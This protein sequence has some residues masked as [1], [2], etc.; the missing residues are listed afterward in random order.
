[1]PNHRRFLFCNPF[2]FIF[3]RFRLREFPIFRVFFPHIRGE[4]FLLSYIIGNQFA[5]PPPGLPGRIQE[6]PLAPSPAH[7]G[8][9]DDRPVLQQRRL[10]TN[11][12]HSGAARQ[13]QAEPL[14]LPQRRPILLCRTRFSPNET[15]SS[16]IHPGILSNRCL[17]YYNVIFRLCDSTAPL[18]PVQPLK[19]AK[20]TAIP[21]PRSTPRLR[22]VP[23]AMDPAHFRAAAPGFYWVL[24]SCHQLPRSFCSLLEP[25]FSCLFFP[26]P[27]S[28]Q[29]VLS[30]HFFN[31][32][33]GGLS[34][35][36]GSLSIP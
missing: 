31:L 19:S 9:T 29:I 6:P 1:M 13:A 24:A 36:F 8:A 32:I 20:I 35:P 26:V 3:Q 11:Q 33:P 4:C 7:M 2:V 14:L 28:V 21:R 12:N 18:H 15:A 22:S 27:Y 25:L 34:L 5:A 30:R 16:R 10:L 17:P 23:E